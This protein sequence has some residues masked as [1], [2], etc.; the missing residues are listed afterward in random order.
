MWFVGGEVQ[1]GFLMIVLSEFVRQN[2]GLA[3]IWG[4]IKLTSTANVYW[5]SMI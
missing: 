3:Q 1:D 2:Q 5:A 4:Q